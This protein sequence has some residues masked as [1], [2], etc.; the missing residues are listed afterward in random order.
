MLLQFSNYFP[1]HGWDSK[2]ASPIL[3]LE[4]APFSLS[5][6][7][8]ENSTPSAKCLNTRVFILFCS[9]FFFI[10][11]FRILLQLIVKQLN[12]YNCVI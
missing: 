7:I 8:R 1:K 3:V 11:I 4:E 9:M 6:G 2:N 12:E 5:L 10:F